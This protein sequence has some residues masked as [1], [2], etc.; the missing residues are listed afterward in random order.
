MIT[1]FWFE[2]WPITIPMQPSV[3][4][5]QGNQLGQIPL[6]PPLPGT[7]LPARRRNTRNLP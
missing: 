2:P 1:L 3:P 6:L 7:L 4:L 5:T